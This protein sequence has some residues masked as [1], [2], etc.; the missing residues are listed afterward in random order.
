MYSVIIVD[1]KSMNKT[2]D[3]IERF[4][5]QSINN[6]LN[7]YIVVD[8]SPQKQCD[9]FCGNGYV[10]KKHIEIDEDVIYVFVKNDEKI[11][12]CFANDNLGYAKGNNLGAKISRALFRDEYYIFSNNDLALKTKFDGEVFNKLFLSNKD[13]AV[14]GP[15]IVGKDGKEQSP[16]KRISAVIRLIAYYWL[17]RWPFRWKPDYDYN[18][19]SKYCYRVMGCF[20]I[21][22]AQCFELVGGFDTK[23]FLFAEEP[24]LSERLLKKHFKT[25]FYN[26]WTIVHEH[27]ASIKKIGYVLKSEQ[28]AFDS[29]CYYYKQYRNVSNVVLF[30]AK[31]NFAFYKLST[32]LIDKLKNV[33][34]S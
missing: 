30:I 4:R 32:S 18:G 13:I 23:T 34:R 21:V 14:I 20:M 31:I 9:I 28:W 25:Y 16:H 8:N 11:Y 7:H 26:E 5:E 6:E 33:I 2:I 19:C 27:G 29:N 10:D 1:Y 12:Y 24:I 3:Y 22:K 17:Y 15:R